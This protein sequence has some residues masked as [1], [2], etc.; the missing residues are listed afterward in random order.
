MKLIFTFSDA[1]E[2]ADYFLKRTFRP[3][4]YGRAELLN[5]NAP[6]EANVLA[7]L[8]EIRSAE[9]FMSVSDDTLRQIKD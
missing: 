4:V 9:N 7:I 1:K 8:K 5:L 6:T 3:N 2:R